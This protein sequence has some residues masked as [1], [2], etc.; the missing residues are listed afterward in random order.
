MTLF[1]TLAAAMIVVALALLAPT[2]LRRQRAGS[3]DTAV[4]NV[5]VARDR[6]AEL[7]RARDTGDLSDEEFAQAR[8][9]LEVALAQ[10]LE[11]PA[12]APAA[13]VNR[14]GRSA[15]IAAAVLVP[16]V[17]VPVY[18]QIG[19]PE[20]IDGVA[21][22][23]PLSA[24]EL[25]PMDVLAEQL[26]ERLEATPDA[27]PEGWFLLGRTYMRLDDFAG[28]AKA[29]E[30]FVELVPDE[31]AGL[32]SLAD[33]LTMRD[34]GRSGPRAVELLNKALTLDPDSV[35]AL[36]LLGNADYEAGRTDEALD[37]WQRAYPLLASEPGMQTEL[38]RLIRQAGG[39]VPASAAEL[40][41][42]MSTAGLAPP[43]APEAAP[44][45]GED[46]GGA[47]ITVQVA[48]APALMDKAAPGDTVFVLA[49]ADDGPPMP[50]AVA[51]HRVDEL[52]LTVTLT[53]QM[54]MMPALKLSTF[55]RVKVS[56]RVSK[57]GQATTQPG[58][59][60]AANAVV[61]SAA[62]PEVVQ[63][64]INEVVQ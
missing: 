15:L 35:T 39:E 38:G 57:S 25:P 7:A 34:G 53:D 51:R 20:L 23:Q 47:A 27:A 26:R 17:T 21:P 4:V 16:L 58:D 31:P 28:A 12:A 45:A 19:A 18:Y 50:L 9:D 29:F 63:L 14:G 33:A 61:D 49:R 64:L 32:L 54:A 10:D 6:L 36:W 8:R 1:W 11:T 24:D 13:T 59:L 22:A 30:R 37:K 41:P 43:A 40:P 60:A 44:A 48:L 55:P 46:G 62:P 52:P 42:I 2:L 5:E 56:A 3:D